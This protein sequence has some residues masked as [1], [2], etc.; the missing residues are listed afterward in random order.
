LRK[1]TRDVG[2]L[3]SINLVQINAADPFGSEQVG[4]GSPLLL[5]LLQTLYGFRGECACDPIVGAIAALG[6]EGG[7]PRKMDRFG[8]RIF[9]AGALKKQFC[10][11]QELGERRLS[12]RLM[13]NACCLLRLRFKM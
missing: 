11:L 1:G 4:S 10:L 2:S 12:V 6:I 13:D 5:C 8:N 9:F 3:C 7:Q